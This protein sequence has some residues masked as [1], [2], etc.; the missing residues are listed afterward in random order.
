MT[1]AVLGETVGFLPLRC[2][3]VPPLGFPAVLQLTLMAALTAAVSMA[4][5]AAAA[6]QEGDPAEA[7]ATLDEQHTASGGLQTAGG[8]GTTRKFVGPPIRLPYAEL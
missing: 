7:A 1:A 4:P 2:L 8:R 3:A 5:E 6:D